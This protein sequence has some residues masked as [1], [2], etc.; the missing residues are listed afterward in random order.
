LLKEQLKEQKQQ[1]KENYIDK[2]DIFY[3]GC[4]KTMRNYVA[5][6]KVSHKKA[7]NSEN[8]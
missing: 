5:K 6:K 8:I 4:T 1:D 7:E 2:I 3:Y